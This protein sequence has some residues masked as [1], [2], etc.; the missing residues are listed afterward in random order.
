MSYAYNLAHSGPSDSGF[1]HNTKYIHPRN[2]L[3]SLVAARGR[4]P[5]SIRALW[6]PTM[7]ARGPRVDVVQRNNLEPDGPGPIW[8][9]FDVKR[10]N[11]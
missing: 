11:S 10:Q 4:V 5:R 1:L 7:K 3:L 9:N 8:M 2:H 6:Q